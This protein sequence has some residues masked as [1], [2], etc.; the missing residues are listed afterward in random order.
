MYTFSACLSVDW[1]HT[2]IKKWLTNV[3]STAPVWLAYFLLGALMIAMYLMIVG[4]LKPA[5]EK[6]RKR[7]EREF[8][9][10]LSTVQETL[11]RKTT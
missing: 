6:R 3:D 1:W 7:L 9:E 8:D 2:Q 11:K 4:K 10:W 5:I